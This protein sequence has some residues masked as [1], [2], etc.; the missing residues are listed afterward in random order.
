[1]S[2]LA[3]PAVTCLFLCDFDGTIIPQDVSDALLGRF[4]LPEWHDI[5]TAWREGRLTARECMQ[6]QVSLLRVEHGQLDA[7]LD[8]VEMDPDFPEFVRQVSARGWQLR[9]VSD[10]LDY[11]I[12]RIFRRYGLTQLPVFA[13]H[14]QLLDTDRYQLSFPHQESA[15]RSGSGTCKCAVAEKSLG[16]SVVPILLGD[17]SSDYCLAHQVRQ[18]WAKD[19]LLRYCQQQGLPHWPFTGFAE[20]VRRLQGREWL[21]ELVNNGQNAQG[22]E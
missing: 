5:E 13:N 11:A 14:L 9:V 6:Q 2:L 16:E 1:M 3:P 15:C 8:Q 4:A 22:R 20:A 19:R 21:S 18:V 10:G 7:F 12:W 17:G